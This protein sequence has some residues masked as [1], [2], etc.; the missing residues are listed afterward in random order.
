MFAQAFDPDSLELSGDLVAVA[1]D[2]ETHVD[3]GYAIFSVSG[4]GVLVYTSSASNVAQQVRLAWF[5]R[6]G[7]S[8]R[9]V[10]LPA[11]YRHPWLSPDETR[12]VFD[13]RAP[14]SNVSDIWTMDLERGSTSRVT[15]GTS[16]SV[17]PIWS[18]GGDQVLFASAREGG[19]KNLYVKPATG[20]GE[21]RTVFSSPHD[22]N[23]TDW[24]RDGGRLLFEHRDPQSKSDVWV[25][26]LSNGRASP[27]LQS[28]FYEQQ[29]VFSP[30]ARWVAY[31][32]DETG[33]CTLRMGAAR[34][35]FQAQVLGL[36][37]VRNHYVVSRDGQRFLF[38]IPAQEGVA[39]PFT[40]VLNWTGAIR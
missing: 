3:R 31:I 18:P 1:H 20:A 16:R 7:K 24:S 33:R 40:V 11:D 36:T 15:F 10:G 2:I 35:L 12:I 6:N 22:K 5:D 8:L 39:S 21:D 13:R 30:D 19:N 23:P 28:P 25:L 34:T 26:D 38:A 4:G 27:F 14:A 9:Q 32:S 17:Q 37:D 29:A